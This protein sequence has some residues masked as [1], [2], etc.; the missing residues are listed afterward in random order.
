MG[1]EW[2]GVCGGGEGV[3]AM[4][5]M[6]VEVDGCGGAW[7]APFAH[8]IRIYQ[9]SNGLARRRRR[10]FEAAALEIFCG[11]RAGRVLD[12]MILR[13]PIRDVAALYGR[14]LVLV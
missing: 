4:A 12:D 2:G 9:K 7:A 11:R 13:A 8:G 10:G 5:P 1:G 3:D 14:D 6:R